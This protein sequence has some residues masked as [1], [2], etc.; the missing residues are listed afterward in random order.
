MEWYW[1]ALIVYLIIGVLFTIYGAIVNDDEV[2]FVVGLL[3]Y[4]IFTVMY[5]L[6]IIIVGI[7]ERRKKKHE[8]TI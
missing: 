5:P 7:Q 8:K 2:S 1:I 4:S 6:I 3:A